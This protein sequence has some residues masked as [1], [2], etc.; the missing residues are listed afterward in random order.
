[1]GNC[2]CSDSQCTMVYTTSGKGPVMWTSPDCPKM[3]TKPTYASILIYDGVSSSFWGD[4]SSE[5][6]VCLPNIQT[7]SIDNIQYIIGMTPQGC[8]FKMPVTSI[9]ITL[10]PENPGDPPVTGKILF[11]PD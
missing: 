3:L 6:P 1:M 9:P 4:G 11:V 7:G 8:M 10:C 5:K 2:G